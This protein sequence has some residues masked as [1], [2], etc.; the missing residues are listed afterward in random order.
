MTEG[1]RQ[2]VRKNTDDP[3]SASPRN[4]QWA[5]IFDWDGVLADSAGP[6]LESWHR[7][8]REEGRSLPSDFFLAS[9]GK[10]N[11]W[12]IPHLLRWTEDPR[13]ISRIGERKEELYRAIVA[14]RGVELY[15][16]GLTLC[17][18]VA[19]RSIPMAIASSTARANIE[20]TLERSALR[21][22]FATVVSAENVRQGKPDPEVFLLAA[23][24]LGFPPERCVVF[25]DAPAGVEAG[26]RAG[27]RVIA[28]TTTNPAEALRKADRT[29]PGLEGMTASGIE[30]WFYA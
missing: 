13:E 29:L 22:F 6:H 5:A 17:Q 2:E 12:V 18:S 4:G 25:E 19:E 28:V 30:E 26:K 9:F 20:L 15:P 21:P 27:M 3:V 23:E 24:R 16:G 8:A 10:K 1:T 14:V 7:L 11:D